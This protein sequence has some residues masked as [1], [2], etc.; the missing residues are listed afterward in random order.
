MIQVRKYSIYE[1]DVGEETKLEYPSTPSAAGL[2]EEDI[3]IEQERIS[4][5]SQSPNVPKEEKKEEIQ[6]ISE[7][8]EIIGQE[9]YK[10][11]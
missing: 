4:L 10:K 7:A 6:K 11:Q 2:K 9:E 5:F 3:K 1:L 8:F